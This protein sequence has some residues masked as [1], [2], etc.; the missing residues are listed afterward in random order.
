[1]A[2]Q[3]NSAIASG[4]GIN[5]ETLML[6]EGVCGG[7]P[8][9]SVELSAAWGGKLIYGLEKIKIIVDAIRDQAEENL[10]GLAV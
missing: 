1:M 4:L 2:L 5:R 3:S 9:K 10:Q 6:W 7:R 8:R